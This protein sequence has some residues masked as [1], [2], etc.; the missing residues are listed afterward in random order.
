MT[1]SAQ[2]VAATARTAG[3]ARG[4][5]A[6]PLALIMAGGTGGHVFPRS[7]WRVNCT[8]AAGA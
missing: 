2:T 3:T 8:R 1:L 7:R 6:M 5:A 4:S